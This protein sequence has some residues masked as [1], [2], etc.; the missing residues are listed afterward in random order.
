M[1]VVQSDISDRGD[2]GEE[3]GLGRGTEKHFCRSAV[4]TT[5]LVIIILFLLVMTTICCY[6]A[7]MDRPTM[8]TGW[9]QLSIDRITTTPPRQQQ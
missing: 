3:W 5:H 7:T 4:A 6:C 1:K 9:C 8:Q 2:D